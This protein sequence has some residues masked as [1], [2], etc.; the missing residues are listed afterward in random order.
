MDTLIQ[1]AQCGDRRAVRELLMTHRNLVESVVRRFLWDK[2][3]WED[4]VQSAMLRVVDSIND[5]A[6]KCRF[7]TWLYRIV[8]NECIEANRRSSRQ[9]T[10]IDGAYDTIEIFADQNAP[11]GL[12]ETIRL[13]QN[14]AVREAV[15]RLPVGMK[16]AF[17]L[18]YGKGYAGAEV[19][20]ELAITE[21][22]LF[23]RLSDARKKLKQELIDR[24]IVPC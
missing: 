1:R 16:Q 23:V 19:A 10:R 15:S 7:S 8:V 3:M 21:K 13:E 14:L 6:G 12:A 24:G 11:D 4:V 2:G 20:K 17:E 18:F 9:K 5:F 22:A